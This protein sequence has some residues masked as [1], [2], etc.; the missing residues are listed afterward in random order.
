[1][2]VVDDDP[3]IRMVVRRTLNG[4]GCVTDTLSNG[5]DAIRMLEMSPFDVV[6]LDLDLPGIG[7]LDVARVIRDPGSQVLDHALPIVALTMRTG[8]EDRRLC[9][10]AG[11][12]GFVPKPVRVK[13][14][15]RAVRSQMGARRPRAG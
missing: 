14:L 12:N 10:E 5:E 2:L 6:L 13:D 4:L 8:D 9:G 3:M 7:G 15:A 11:M 1:V